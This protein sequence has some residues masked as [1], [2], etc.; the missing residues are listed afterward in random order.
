MDID[1]YTV[2]ASA[3]G[4][5]ERSEERSATMIA[6]LEHIQLSCS[7]V[8]RTPNLCAVEHSIPEPNLFC[9]LVFGFYFF[10]LRCGS[11]GRG[12]HVM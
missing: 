2:A 7:R 3:C 1:K 4:M 6:T 11:A 9:C 10:T 8:S 5:G 12:G